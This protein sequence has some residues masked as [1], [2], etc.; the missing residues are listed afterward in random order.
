MRATG[1]NDGIRVW[2]SLRGV[3]AKQP[4]IARMPQDRPRLKK[5]RRA[6][7]VQI[8]TAEG[9]S[10][11]RRRHRSIGRGRSRSFS[12]AIGVMW[13]PKQRRGGVQPIYRVRPRC[14]LSITDIGER[15]SESPNPAR[16]SHPVT[17]AI[18]S[19]VHRMVPRQSRQRPRMALEEPVYLRCLNPARRRARCH[20]P[21]Q[22]RVQHLNMRRAVGLLHLH[23]IGVAAA[24]LEAP[25]RLCLDDAPCVGCR[26]QR[27]RMFS[28]LGSQQRTFSTNS[29]TG[30]AVRSPRTRLRPR[31]WIDGPSSQ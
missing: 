2:L 12:F 6:G 15:R 5:Y 1:K 25:C 30:I 10:Q 19:S 28:R 7:T 3:I 14:S 13:C 4:A 29:A 16:S 23:R 20:Q 8:Q 31:R 17:L 11:Q 22:L 27:E 24:S 18:R 26:G 9:F 21:E